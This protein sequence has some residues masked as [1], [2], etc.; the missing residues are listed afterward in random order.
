M[1]L[2]DD[3][4][5]TPFLLINE[6][7]VKIQALF[8]PLGGEDVVAGVAAD[9]TLAPLSSQLAT[10]IPKPVQ[11]TFAPLSACMVKSVD[12]FIGGVAAC[13]PAGGGVTVGDAEEVL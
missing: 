11:V 8:A 13:A 6:L 2:H 1:L 12:D 3:V 9:G 5:G 7:S 10:M 4:F